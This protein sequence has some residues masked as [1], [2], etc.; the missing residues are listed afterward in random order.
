MK[1]KA[2]I[3]LINEHLRKINK[4]CPYYAIAQLRHDCAV[5]FGFVNWKHLTLAKEEK[6]AECIKSKPL[7]GFKVEPQVCH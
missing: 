6:L 5:Y 4:V 2:P 7:L 3:E 1:P